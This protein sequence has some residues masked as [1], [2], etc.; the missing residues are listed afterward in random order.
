MSGC[1]KRNLFMLT[2]TP[3]KKANQYAYHHL[4]CRIE[5]AFCYKQETLGAFLDVEETLNSI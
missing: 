4:V 3:A 5:D 2:N 1:Y